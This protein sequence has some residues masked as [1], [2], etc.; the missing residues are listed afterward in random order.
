MKRKTLDLVFSAGG[1]VT[2]VLILILGL[3]MNNE[4]N[5]AHTYVKD[6]FAQQRISFTPAEYL[7][8]EEKNADP[9]I[10]ANAGKPLETGEQAACY[11]NFYIGTH[12]KATNDGKT[13][14]E[15]STQAREAHTKATEAADAGQADADE[16]LEEA[17]ALDAKADTL[18]RG[19]SL[20]GL[21]L[22]AYGFSILGVRAGQAATVAFLVAAVLAL[23][24]I[25]GFI[26]AA[27]A[28]DELVRLGGKGGDEDDA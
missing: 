7:S 17:K 23:A 20:R 13:Y 3:V 22:T 28:G 6:Q 11:A 27:T 5:F 8:D 24:S 2:A 16:L 10:V 21:L 18:F 19:E 15:T 14:S 12:L 4:A 1:L 9:C 26:H 25:A